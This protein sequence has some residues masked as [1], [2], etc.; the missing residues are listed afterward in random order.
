MQLRTF[1]FAVRSG[2]GR[3]LRCRAPKPASGRSLNDIINDM[4]DPDNV[5]RVQRLPPSMQPT[6]DYNRPTPVTVL[7]ASQSQQSTTQ[8]STSQREAQL[9]KTLKKANKAFQQLGEA[10]VSKEGVMGGSLA[11]SILLNLQPH[12]L[13]FSHFR[14]T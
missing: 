14:A 3:F 1:T 8:D 6:Q 4:R 9:E 5:R 12:V 11:F 10:L 2:S 7:P 13:Y